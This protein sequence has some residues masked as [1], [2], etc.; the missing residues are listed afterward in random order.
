MKKWLIGLGCF[1]AACT[2]NTPDSGKKSG[3]QS[4]PVKDP[5]VLAYERILGQF[6]DSS[7]LRMAFVQYLDSTQ[8]FYL[9]LQQ[10]DSLIIRDSLNADLWQ[11]K[12]GIAEKAKDTSQA[13]HA[14]IQSLKIFNRNPQAM[15]FLAHLLAEKKD[16]SCLALCEELD[17]MRIGQPYYNHTNFLRG[18]YY[19]R[20]GNEASA[21]KYFQSCINNDFRY[22]RAHLEWVFLDYD[23]GRYADALAYITKA[24]PLVPTDPDLFY[25]R[26]KCEEK[27]QQK[28]A[29][30]RHYEAALLIDP[31]MKEARTALDR[32]KK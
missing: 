27:M 26:A 19:A 14:Y 31:D 20:T 29:A 12:A 9:A 4:L 6:P 22:V 2:N 15:L 32:L 17:K 18:L 11:A 23:K 10:T 1:F 7:A 24:Q 3:T 25:W 13:I 16:K 30:I 21:K 8:Q 28:E 5:Q